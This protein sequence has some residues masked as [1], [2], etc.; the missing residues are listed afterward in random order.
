[1][2]ADKYV[3]PA[4]RQCCQHV[5]PRLTLVASCEQGKT[6]ACLFRKR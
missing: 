3:D 2:C 1:M 5:L 6:Q 4:P